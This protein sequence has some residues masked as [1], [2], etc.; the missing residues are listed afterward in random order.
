MRKIQKN[1]LTTLAF[2]LLT[3]LAFAIIYVTSKVNLRP[4]SISN[5]TS[6]N[7]GDTLLLTDRQAGNI[8]LEKFLEMASLSRH[9]DK[10]KDFSREGDSAVFTIR[11]KEL[12]FGIV[13][14]DTKHW[15]VRYKNLPIRVN[16]KYFKAKINVT[17]DKE[18]IY[19]P[20]KILTSVA[21]AVEQNI[22]HSSRE[23][24][25]GEDTIVRQTINNERLS[26]LSLS[27]ENLSSG[28]IQ[29]GGIVKKNLFEILSDHPQLSGDRYSQLKAAWTHVYKHWNYINDPYS[30]TDTWRPAN[31]TIEDYY[32]VSGKCYSGDCDDF[33]ILMAS[34]AK[35]LGYETQFCVAVMNGEGHAFARFRERGERQWH[36]LDWFGGFDGRSEY[37]NHIKRTY[38]TL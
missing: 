1:L 34:F 15:L 2:V 7:T 10:N 24:L 35:Q 25:A 30:E 28:K 4:G 27:D 20:Y 19:I 17:N 36:S 21:K 14:E 16:D 9:F 37:E 18:Y 33:A 29:T 38:S 13:D 12:F 5:Y 8:N 11:S 26:Q 3:T 22:S 6:Y 31:E 23:S 32:Y